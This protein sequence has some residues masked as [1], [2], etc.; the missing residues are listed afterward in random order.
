MPNYEAFPQMGFASGAKQGPHT[1]AVMLEGHFDSAF[2]DKSSPLAAGDTKDANAASKSDA[3]AG[4]N[5][6]DDKSTNK[7]A[8]PIDSVIQYSPGSSRLIVVGSSAMFDDQATSLITQSLGTHYLKPEEFVQNVVDWSLADQGLLSIRSRE[9]FART[10]RPLSRES[11]E[12]W[13]YLNY[14]LALGGLV[15]IWLI[16]RRRRHQR[17]ARHLKL[18]AEV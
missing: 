16:N 7:S 13:E 2:K 1:L 18:L 3:N 6:T 10:L 11:E 9:Q 5:K 12:F 8:P 15:L 4:A 17:V 14:G